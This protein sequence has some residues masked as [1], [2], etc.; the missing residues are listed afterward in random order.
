MVNINNLLNKL[1]KLGV[2][3]GIDVRVMDYDLF[4]KNDVIGRGETAGEDGGVHIHCSREEEKKPD[5]FFELVTGGKSIDLETNRLVSSDR[6]DPAKPRFLL[7]EK[8]SSK[9]KFSVDHT[10]GV[11]KIILL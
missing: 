1:Q 10:P 6:R 9:N 2:P 5:V 8:W 7:P 3:A 11:V 4:S